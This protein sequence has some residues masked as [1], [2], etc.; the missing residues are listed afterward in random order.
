[1][2]VAAIYSR[3]S[4]D[5]TG[6]A[7]DQRSVVRQVEHAK[8]YATKKGWHVDDQFVFVDD[9]ISG[10]EFDARPGYM[11]MLNTLRPR[12]PFDVLIVSELSRLGREQFETNYMLKT[13]SQAGVAVWSY[14]EDR[15][16]ALD[17]PTDKF[18]VSAMSFAAEL[19]RQKAAQRIWFYHSYI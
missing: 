7:E 19:E 5:Q 12:A 4:T 16:A 8:D 17:D 3:K 1:M 15:V 2:T 6:V 10:A 11:R 9:G 13:L 14:L 18:M